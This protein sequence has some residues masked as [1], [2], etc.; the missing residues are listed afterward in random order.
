MQT[1]I[2]EQI[3]QGYTRHRA[4]D[5]RIVAALIERLAL[6]ARSTIVDIGAG[7][8]NYSAALA[9]H[10]QQVIAVEPSATMRR[11]AQPAPGLRWVAGVAEALPLRRHS[12]DGVVC[13]LALHHFPQLE[14]A[15]AEM[16]RVCP[17]GPIVI[18]TFDPR[19]AESFWFAEYFPEVWQAAF[20]FFPPLETL[21]AKIAAATDRPVHVTP[22]RLPPDLHDRFAAAGWRTPEIYLDPQVRAGMSPFAL[23]DQMTIAVGVARLA[24]DLASGAWQAR[25]GALVARPDFDAGYRFLSVTVLAG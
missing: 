22:F 19:A 15:L 7:S 24:D 8:G 1:P 17:A 25:H 12:A 4:A 10:G 20:A 13:T 21:V 18:L 11:Q 6:P 14:R 5:P 23:G 2:Y 3:G 16:Q 9:R